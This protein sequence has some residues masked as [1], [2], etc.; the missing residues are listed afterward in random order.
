M[1]TPNVGITGDDLRRTVIWITEQI[2]QPGDTPICRACGH[3]LEHHLADRSLRS[4]TYPRGLGAP[5][6]LCSCLDY[7]PG[8][9]D[10]G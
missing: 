9:T 8:G 1:T 10:E 2:E 5:K 6:K 3:G 4:C 7:D